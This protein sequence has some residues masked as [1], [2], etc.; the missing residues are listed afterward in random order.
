MNLKKKITPIYYIIVL[1]MLCNCVQTTTALFGPAITINKTGNVY[2]AGLSYV[3]NDIIKDRIGKTPTE[4]IRDNILNKSQTKKSD[5]MHNG[6]NALI[7]KKKLLVS[8]NN[9]AEHESF[10]N[11]LKKILK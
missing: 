3:S 4:F 11:A 10:I 5:Q 9:E 1:L 2:H 6:N 8:T 7:D